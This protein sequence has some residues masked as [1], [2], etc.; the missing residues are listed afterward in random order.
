MFGH[1]RQ[2]VV[3]GSFPTPSPFQGEGR[4][5]VSPYE[6][7][8]VGIDTVVANAGDKSGGLTWKTAKVGVDGAFDL[9]HSGLTGPTENASA[10][11]SFY[12]W[13]PRPLDNLLVEPNM[14]KLDLLMGSDDGC[15]LFL[16][17]KLVK[18]DRGIHPVTPD[19]IIAEAL[20][21]QR[22]WN[23]FIVKVVQVGGGWG[24]TARFRCSDPKFMGGLKTSVVR[25]STGE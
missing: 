19:S 22:G 9:L 4:G 20:P 14:P 12:V 7:D 15:Q 17:G 8:N 1:L 10:Y 6:V 24:F 18:E 25:A 16:N 5:E 13:S 23:H 11:L 2:A 3:C 21:L